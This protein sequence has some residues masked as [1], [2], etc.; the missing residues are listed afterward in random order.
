MVCQVR[1]ELRAQSRVLRARP[2]WQGSSWGW[3]KGRSWGRLPEKGALPVV[4][5]M[6]A[7]ETVGIGSGGGYGGGGGTGEGT[8][9]GVVDQ[10]GK[11]GGAMGIPATGRNV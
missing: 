5:A 11:T 10:C 1:A 6:V 8:E 9:A 4:G 3:D 7:A 2:R